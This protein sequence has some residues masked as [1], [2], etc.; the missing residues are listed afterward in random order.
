MV[1]E[2]ITLACQ[3]CKRRNYTTMKDKKKHPERIELS[4]YCRFERKHT[5]HK[6]TK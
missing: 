1:R 6:E 2:I 3:G 5:V 4:K